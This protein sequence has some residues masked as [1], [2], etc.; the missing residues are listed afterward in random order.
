VLVRACDIADAKLEWDEYPSQAKGIYTSLEGPPEMGKS[1][2]LADSMA[3]YTRKGQDV[4]LHADEDLLD[5]TWKPR[6]RAAG[7][8]LKRVHFVTATRDNTGKVVPFYLTD[9]AVLLARKAKEIPA[10]R[11]FLDSVVSA[12]GSRGR[13]VDTHRE[14]D[15]RDSLRPLFDLGVG[16]TGIR[17]HRKAAGAKAAEAGN[18]SQAFYALARIVLTV[19]PDPHD[20][21]R[22]LLAMSKNNLVPPADKVTRTYRIVP[23]DSDPT[24][25][26]IKWEGTSSVTADEAMAAMVEAEADARGGV[27]AEAKAFLLEALSDG[28]GHPSDEVIKLASERGMSERSLWRAKGKVGGIRARKQ[29][30]RWY[31]YMAKDGER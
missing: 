13:R 20:T 3:T 22:R 15:V 30:E 23:S 31:W 7:A 11:I 27:M 29:G 6:L 2:L 8:D 26:C 19:V 1:T 28:Q 5:V 9:D 21:G 10:A 12:M 16:V 24:I 4:I 17:H 25:P 18:G 14:K